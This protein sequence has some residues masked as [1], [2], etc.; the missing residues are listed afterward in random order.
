MA[1]ETM[2]GDSPREEQGFVRLQGEAATADHLPPATPPVAVVP[3]DRRHV[4]KVLVVDDSPSDRE[5][6]V[7]QLGRIWPFEREMAVV[8]A[9]SGEE[10]LEKIFTS[11]LSLVVLDWNL[12]RMSGVE[13]L[14]AARRY[15][16]DL[17]IVV[18]SGLRREEIKVNLEEL[19]AAFVNKDELDGSRFEN[20]IARSILLQSRSEVVAAA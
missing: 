17:P 14:K 18:L 11:R 15:Q 9:A 3:S 13:V 20:A 8:T 6:T 2:T 12:P 16:V 7:Y 5:L 4:L 10:A 1:G 19:G